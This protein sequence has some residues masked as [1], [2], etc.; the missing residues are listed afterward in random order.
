MVRRCGDSHRRHPAMARRLSGRSARRAVTTM[1]AVLALAGLGLQPAP[2]AA[3]ASANL[4]LHYDF[5]TLTDGTVKDSSGSG[6]DGTLVN[7]SSA[8]TT[9]GVDGSPALVLPGGAATS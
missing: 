9:T 1:A 8:S 5:D 4:V 2:T 6:L 3:A 7:A